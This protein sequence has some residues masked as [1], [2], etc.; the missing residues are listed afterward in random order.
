MTKELFLLIQIILIIIVQKLIILK[1][2]VE[3]I[4][5]YIV[6]VKKQNV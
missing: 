6:H 4:V 3:K 2:N 1:M 5:K